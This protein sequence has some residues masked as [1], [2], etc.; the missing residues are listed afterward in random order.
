MLTYVVHTCCFTINANPFALLTYLFCFI[1]IMDS[2][3]VNGYIGR[4][5][6]VKFMVFV[7]KILKIKVKIFKDKICEI[8]LWI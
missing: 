2:R 8:F 5:L 4:D 1:L 6:E 3:G 7:L